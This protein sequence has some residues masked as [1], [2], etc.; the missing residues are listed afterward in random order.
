MVMREDQGVLK[1]LLWGRHSAM[2]A[3]VADHVWKVEEVVA[4]LEA[5]ERGQGE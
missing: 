2:A 1:I 3:G 5:R 4:L